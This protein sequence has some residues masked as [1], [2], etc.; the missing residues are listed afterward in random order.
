MEREKSIKSKFNYYDLINKN[1]NP[2]R[3]DYREN[4]N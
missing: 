4:K 3:G 1:I 2:N